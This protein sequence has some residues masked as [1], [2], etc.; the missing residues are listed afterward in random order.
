MLPSPATLVLA[1]L[2]LAASLNTDDSRCRLSNYS[3]VQPERRL[4]DMG[5]K[6][7]GS[8]RGCVTLPG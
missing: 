2:A 5:T 7:R 3:W 1:A 8:A 4:R 6:S